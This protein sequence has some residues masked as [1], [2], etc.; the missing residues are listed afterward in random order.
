MVLSVSIVG[1]IIVVVLLG[2]AFARGPRR[3]P[4]DLGAVSDGWIAQH[5]VSWYD[6]HR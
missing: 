5:R 2:G 6:E 4:A 1:A 3:K